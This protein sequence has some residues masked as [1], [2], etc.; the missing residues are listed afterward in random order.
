MNVLA[1][2]LLLAS[3]ETFD[4]PLDPQ[5]WLVGAPNKP[6]KGKLLLPR[7]GWIAARGIEKIVRLEIRFRHKGG[8][9]E[10][11]FHDAREPLGR[12]TAPPIRVPKGKGDR[13]LVLSPVGL[14]VDADRLEWS[15]KLTGAFRIAALDGAVEIDEVK[16]SPTPKALRTPTTL[17]RDTLF[18]MTTPQVDGD[19]RRV[20]M[21]LWDVPISFLFA[22]GATSMKPLQGPGKGATILAQYVRVSNGAELALKAAAHPMAM[23]SWADE[24]A[25][26]DAKAFQQYVAG[27]YAQFELLEQAQRVLNSAVDSKVDLEPLVALA[28]IRHADDARAA[29]ALAETRKSKKALALLR[30]ELKGARAGHDQLRAAAGRAARKLLEGRAPAAWRNF[31]F[32]PQ[33]RYLTMQEVREHLR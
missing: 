15:G 12:P 16:V 25:N 1:G 14:R 27:V 20:T 10:L 9:L 13:V 2:L 5:R 24:R 18:W 4:Q 7:D 17:E 28:V 32:D 26:L 19:F 33:E 11:T 29:Y 21:T 31:S 3:F 30:A 6:K 22:R 23:R 8:A